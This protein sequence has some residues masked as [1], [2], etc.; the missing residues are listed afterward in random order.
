MSSDARD[1]VLERAERIRIEGVVQGVGFRYSAQQL[2][3]RH[4]LRGWVANV[5]RGVVVHAC[6]PVDRLEGFVRAL[7]HDIGPPARVESLER[8]PADMLPAGAGFR[9][10]PS[11]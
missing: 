3:I 1:E 9:I 10:A 7:R 8:E 4:G 6:G 2:A 11:R 5:G